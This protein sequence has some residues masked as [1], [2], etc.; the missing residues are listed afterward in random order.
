MKIYL[1]LFLCAIFFINLNIFSQV[2]LIPNQ[3]FE[4]H[5]SSRD[6]YDNVESD[7]N[8]GDL[9]GC[10]YDPPSIRTNREFDGDIFSWRSSRRKDY[11]LATRW[12]TTPDYISH[13]RCGWF[14]TLPQTYHSDK[15]MRLNNSSDEEKFY[16]YREGIYVT[17]VNNQKLKKNTEYILKYMAA[18]T[19]IAPGKKLNIYIA[20]KTDDFYR[21]SGHQHL[22]FQVTP[23]LTTDWKE[24]EVKFNTGD[25]DKMKTIAFESQGINIYLDNIRLYEHSCEK[26]IYKQNEYEHNAG[27]AT[28]YETDEYIFIG[29]NVDPNQDFGPYIISSNSYVKFKAGKEIIIAPTGF[30]PEPGASYDLI[31]A[32]CEYDCEMKLPTLLGNQTACSEDCIPIVDISNPLSTD[33][34]YQWQVIPASL[35]SNLNLSDPLNPLFC[36]PSNQTGFAKINLRKINSC[37]ESASTSTYIFFNTTI[38]T[39]PNFQI[40]NIVSSFDPSFDIQLHENTEWFTVEL[41]NQE[42]SNVDYFIQ[43]DRFFDFENLNVSVNLNEIFEIDF[44]FDYTVRVTS[45]NYCNDNTFSESFLLQ[46]TNFQ[47]SINYPNGAF[48]ADISDNLVGCFQS[49][50]VTSAFA[51]IAGRFSLEPLCEI[52]PI[53]EPNEVCFYVE[54]CNI[55]SATYWI[56]AEFYNC[57]NLIFLSAEKD[58]FIINGSN[59]LGVFD[60]IPQNNINL[61]L[62]KLTPNPSSG[63]FNISS[64]FESFSDVLESIE[65]YNSSGNLVLS[66]Y[67]T[68]NLD[69]DLS[70]Q[71][72]GIYFIRLKINGTYYNHKVL[73]MGH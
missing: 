59:R 14:Y 11:V 72:D 38:P 62:Y 66:S 1:H 42:T 49:A 61:P 12:G 28:L 63:I 20:E 65:V 7:D 37:E 22:K 50:G 33:Y 23:D 54:N 32:P 45:K 73:K 26:N 21:A 3:S 30:E 17:L 19:F 29:D 55:S 56:Y 15:L 52:I 70:N 10:D 68:S 9:S 69:I 16:T 39:E 41:I 36:P 47:S 24:F 13:I 34:T 2:N 31:I 18:T 40:S 35:T 25:H 67:A 48:F 6:I 8:D 4:L 53:I 71:N 43:Y 60:T 57:D 5:D 44:C 58:I 51:Y 64:E 46:F 27:I